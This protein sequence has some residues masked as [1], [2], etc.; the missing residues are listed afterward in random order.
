MTQ[1]LIVEKNGTI[2]ESDVKLN[3][4]NDLYK[5][6]GFKTAQGF[7]LQT[8]FSTTINK[9]VFNVSL[10]AKTTG[11]AGQENK[12]DFPPPVD[13]KLFFGNCVLLG[14]SSDKIIDLC[15]DQWNQIYEKLFG[16]FEDLGN[17]DSEVSEDEIDDDVSQ[18]K[19]GY[20]KD[21]FIVDDSELELEDAEESEED[22]VDEEEETEED[23]EEEEEEE[24]TEE[25]EDNIIK[26][27][28]KVKKPVKLVIKPP[29]K[30]IIE[31]PEK[32]IRSKKANVDSVKAKLTKVD[33]G[34]Y[35]NCSDELEEEDY[36]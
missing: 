18:T 33:S 7:Q 8:T 36:V 27:S 14:M 19:E 1:I 12:Y 31:P 22:D 32:K 13:E 24:D 21:G 34:N 5:K 4:V 25:E 6:A 2:K 29:I 15:K 16:G 30:P 11:R 9:C 28:K 10:Y 17:E 3:D 23:E 20:V 35:L 26:K